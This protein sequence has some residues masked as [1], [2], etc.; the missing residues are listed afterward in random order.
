VQRIILFRPEE[1]GMQIFR[2]P[3]WDRL[4]FA[5]IAAISFIR[6]GKTANIIFAGLMS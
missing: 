1:P 5:D 2:C 3:A 6:A 4:L